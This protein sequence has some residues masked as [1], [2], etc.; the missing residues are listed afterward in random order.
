MGR[1][2][3]QSS[4]PMNPKIGIDI[5]DQHDYNGLMEWTLSEAKSKLSE[6]CWRAESEP[7]VIIRHGRR[8][9]QDARFTLRFEL[10]GLQVARPNYQNFWKNLRRLKAEMPIRATHSE[11]VAWKNEG[12]A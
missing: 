6:V 9:D 11:M 3:Q 7:Q 1:G 4:L 5:S 10:A 12:R 2:Q 8:G